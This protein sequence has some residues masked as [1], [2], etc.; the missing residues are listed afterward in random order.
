MKHKKKRVP[1]S[2]I[3]TLQA[4]AK[5]GPEKEIEFWAQPKAL[6][7]CIFLSDKGECT[8]YQERPVDCR[9]LNVVSNPKNCAKENPNDEVE[10]FVSL[11]GEAVYAAL[12][13]LNQRQTNPMTI[14]MLEV[15]KARKNNPEMYTQKWIRDVEYL[16][17]QRIYKGPNFK[18]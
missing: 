7:K 18:Q 12:G 4:Q 10:E 9:L 14:A 1:Q 17:T 2:A 5:F 15:I 6:S 8:V 16:K 11:D 3:D 13:E